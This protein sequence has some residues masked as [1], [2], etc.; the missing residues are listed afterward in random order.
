MPGARSALC[1][2]VLACAC[3]RTELFGPLPA[4][5]QAGGG[6]ASNQ[7]GG[8]A[9]QGGGAAGQ[10]GGAASQGGGT[11][12]SG[13]G[14]AS[15]GGGNGTGGGVVDPNRT[16]WRELSAPGPAGRRG[17]GLTWAGTSQGVIMFGGSVSPTR[18]EGDTWLFTQ[19]AWQQL[20]PATHPE[21]REFH[22]MA[23]QSARQRVLLFGGFNQ[24][25]SLADTWEFDGTQWSQVAVTGPSARH[26]SAMAY[27]PTR[28]VTVLFGG[29]LG[30]SDT[31]E[32]NGSTWS[33]RQVAGPPGRSNHTLTWLPP[34]GEVVL[35]G[36]FT[37][38]GS[39][40]DCWRF[41][42]SQWARMSPA[43][44]PTPRNSHAVAFDEAEGHLEL[45]CG[46]GM[47]FLGDTWA[48]D[49]L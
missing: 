14:S 33:Q 44:S 43:M 26:W 9:S 49:L 19:G 8:S 42:G 27:D 6:S 39:V 20:M 35:F 22:S 25:G 38:S 1:L 31:W 21:A 45:F 7:G 16:T 4:E 10:G 18:V 48:F 13:G 47:R 34:L 12:A 15:S 37:A 32:W 23:W 24:R 29:D 3:G 30:E 28:H 5:S 17:H 40:N 36:G 11:M 41:N 46:F 2:V